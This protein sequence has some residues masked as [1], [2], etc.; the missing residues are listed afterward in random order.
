MIG[1]HPVHRKL[2][3]IA[4]MCVDKHGDLVMGMPELKLLMPLL[5]DNFHLIHRL[6]SLKELAF[7]A[8]EMGDLEWEMELCKKIE[9]LEATM[10]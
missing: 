7:H 2:A 6:D 10:L 4:H 5:R 3:T 1:I 9:D 8:H